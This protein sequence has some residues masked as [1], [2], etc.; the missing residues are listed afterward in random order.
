MGLLTPKRIIDPVHGTI[1][2]S[3]LEMKVIDTPVFQ[4]LRNVKQLGF[5]H[6]VFPGADYSRFAHSL[7]VCHLVG[8]QLGALNAD[9]SINET[10]LQDYRLAGLLHDV[11]HYPFSHAFEEAIEAHFKRKMLVPTNGA[12]TSTGTAGALP[13]PGSQYFKHERV[14][15]QILELEPVISAILGAD[16]AKRVVQIF[17]HTEESSPYANLVSSDLDADRIDYMMRT[18]AHSGLPYG[19]VDVE[20]LLSQ[21][22]F[23]DQ[24]K[25]CINAKALRAADH[26]LL[27]RYFDYQQVAF[28]KSVAAFELVLKDV[29]GALLDAGTMQLDRNEVSDMIRN[30]AWIDFDDGK[31]LGDIRKHSQELSHDDPVWTKCQSVLLRKP[32][33]LLGEI[34]QIREYNR[35]S[36]DDFVRYKRALVTS[37]DGW[38]ERH[39]INR[40][41]WYLWD[42]SG[43]TLTKIGASIPTSMLLENPGGGEATLAPTQA[44]FAQAVRVKHQSDGDSE[45]IVEM[46]NSLMS[47]LSRHALYSL[48]VYAHVPDGRN[49]NEIRDQ[50]KASQQGLPWKK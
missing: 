4:R 16:R 5:A 21:L 20:Y 26:F 45:P 33:K 27:C 9:N 11:G 24:R 3:E 47:V 1:S 49:A 2:L 8:R 7:G 6:Y 36:Q 34:E 44:K 18:A 14:G 17:T 43:W 39:G 48:R 41:L 22:T 15:K 32:P 28:H 19:S 12:S 50:I 13:S 25:V 38:A 23:D 37:L 35:A 31:T 30:G 29:I 46:Q 42:S 40:A 10:D